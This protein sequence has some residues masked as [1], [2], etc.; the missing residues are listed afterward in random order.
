MHSLQ[1][2]DAPATLFQASGVVALSPQWSAF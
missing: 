1:I 2:V